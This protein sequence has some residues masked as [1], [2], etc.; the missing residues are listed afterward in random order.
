MML[1]VLIL[2]LVLFAAATSARAEGHDAPLRLGSVPLADASGTLAERL[3]DGPVLVHLWAT[4]CGPCAAEMPEVQAF[5]DTLD[6]A[7]RPR[8]VVASVD[9]VD[10]AIVREWMERRGVERLGSLRV[11]LTAAGA[12]MPIRGFPVTFMLDA[13]RRIV[14]KQDGPI[15]WTKPAIAARL[16]AFLRR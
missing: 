6:P 8:L 4:W 9:R 14:A 11:P 16:K 3:P 1:R 7:M 2:T 10:A 13:N 15:G 5:A 12:A